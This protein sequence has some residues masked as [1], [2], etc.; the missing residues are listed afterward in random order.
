[1]AEDAGFELTIEQLDYV[2]GG[3]SSYSQ[4]TLVC[5]AYELVVNRAAATRQFR[6]LREREGDAVYFCLGTLGQARDAQERALGM[7]D[8]IEPCC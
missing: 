8:P 3:V 4:T 1:M 2:A 5:L 6:L 7:H